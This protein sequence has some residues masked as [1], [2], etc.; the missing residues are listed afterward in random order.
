M[1]TLK[2]CVGDYVQRNRSGGSYAANYKFKIMEITDLDGHTYR[3]ARCHNGS[4]HNFN[5]LKMIKPIE[6]PWQPI[7]G[8]TIR[9]TNS[10][11]AP[12]YTERKFLC[13]NEGRFVCQTHL[14]MDDNHQYFGYLYAQ[15][16]PMD[17]TIT[18]ANGVSIKLSE[19]SYA[20]IIKGVQTL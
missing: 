1:N 14:D 10:I 15:P 19:K 7:Q 13:M 11:E 3:Y 17:T 20:A 2:Y 12:H 5:Y 8:E 4:L 6:R 18:L 16:M 9:V